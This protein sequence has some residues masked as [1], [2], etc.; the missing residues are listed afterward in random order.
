[1]LSD[2]SPRV[3]TQ[4]LCHKRYHRVSNLVV[5]F[6][7]ELYK[8]KATHILIKLDSHTAREIIVILH[9]AVPLCDP[10]WITEICL[11]HADFF[12]VFYAIELIKQILLLS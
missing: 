9:R 10:K 5:C 6:H 12:K 11:N 1:M 4:T 3:V 8:T 7:I 2:I